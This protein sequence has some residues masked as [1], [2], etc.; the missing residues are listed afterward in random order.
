MNPTRE[1][2]CEINQREHGDKPCQMCHTCCLWHR[3]QESSLV[4]ENGVLKDQL[5]NLRTQ[6]TP[7][8]MES[9]PGKGVRIRLLF[10]AEHSGYFGFKIDSQPCGWLPLPEED[11]P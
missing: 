8:P 11:A 10:G 9:A 3:Q 7:R 2:Q 6:L 5:K 4:L 1:K